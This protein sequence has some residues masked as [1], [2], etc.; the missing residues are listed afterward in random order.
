[1]LIEVA[2]LAE[3]H[4]LDELASLIPVFA[5]GYYLRRCYW[6]DWLSVN[7]IGM[8]SVRRIGERT[9]EARLLTSRGIALGRAHV[10]D[11]AIE[12]FSAALKI[13][14]EIDDPAGCATT[15]VNLGNL[16]ERQGRYGEAVA[17]LTDALALA[18]LAGIRSTEATA[19]GNLGTCHDRLGNYEEALS[20]QESS[21]AICREI[22]NRDG[23][24]TAL[25]NIGEVYLHSGRPD[26]ALPCLRQALAIARSTQGR[27]DEA[28]V[29]TNLGKAA[30][31]L[32]HTVDAH[33]HLNEALVIW[34]ALDDP[35]V[36][37]VETLI[38]SLPAL[39]LATFG[40]H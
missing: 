34:R 36:G 31:A 28:L 2:Q 20:L 39:D 5:S 11:Q 15:Q 10:L 21:L 7:E 22:G 12:C 35:Q 30:A 17:Y 38:A 8:R 33:A 37:A 14:E 1:V 18:R 9:R 32:G 26:E 40:L 19:L 16:L 13:W 24:S 23:E 6:P 25:M 27:Y 29:L 3:S 4:R